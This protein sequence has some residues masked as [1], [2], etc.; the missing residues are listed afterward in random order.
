MTPHI[1]AG[2]ASLVLCGSAVFTAVVPHPG[3]TILPLV[4][5]AIYALLGVAYFRHV[6]GAATMGYAVICL[7]F[8]L[9][10]FD[11]SQTRKWGIGLLPSLA[12]VV[13]VHANTRII[14]ARTETTSSSSLDGSDGT[15]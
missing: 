2:I 14:A 12:M 4:G 13:M 1:L 8:V 9:A 5:A 3:S 10:F 7:T 15:P 11:Y 6:K